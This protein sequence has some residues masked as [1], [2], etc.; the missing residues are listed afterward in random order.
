VLYTDGYYVA[1]WGIIDRLAVHD[2]N[3]ALQE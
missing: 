2:W 3:S 1:L